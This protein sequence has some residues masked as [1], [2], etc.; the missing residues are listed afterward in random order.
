M[1]CGFVAADR[2]TLRRIACVGWSERNDKYAPRDF[3][4]HQPMRRR[5]RRVEERIGFPYLVD[6]VDAERN[7]LEQMSRLVIDLERISVVEQIEIEQLGQRTRVYY[8]RMQSNTVLDNQP[9][10][11]FPPPHGRERTTADDAC[12]SS[13]VASYATTQ[14]RIGQTTRFVRVALRIRRL[15]IR[16]PPSALNVSPDQ[17]RGRSDWRTRRGEP[18]A[19]RRARLVWPR[20][21]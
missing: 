17:P 19:I 5:D 21:T 20:P 14:P 12:A 1:H 7:V 9:L 3:G 18:V 11:N 15:G 16:L 10:T 2:S 6:V 8:I 4:R 13:L